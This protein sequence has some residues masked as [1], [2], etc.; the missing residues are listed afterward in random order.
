MIIYD[1]PV[2]IHVPWCWYSDGEHT[3][4]RA[5]EGVDPMFI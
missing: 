2:Y 5:N 4:Y 3:Q 1:V